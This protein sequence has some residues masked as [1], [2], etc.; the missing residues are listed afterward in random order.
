MLNHIKSYSWWANKL[1][2]EDH[3]P[4][5][6]RGRKEKEEWKR[7]TAEACWS[8]KPSYR[9]WLWLVLG[10]S[11]LVSRTLSHSWKG[12]LSGTWSCSRDHLPISSSCGSFQPNLPDALRSKG[13]RMRVMCQHC[14]HLYGVAGGWNKRNLISHAL[15]CH[16]PHLSGAPAPACPDPISSGRHDN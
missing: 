1:W 9:I 3:L 7:T 16:L 13:F 15:C 5:G 2:S 4:P 11:F 10:M 14:H 12:P 6:K 8:L